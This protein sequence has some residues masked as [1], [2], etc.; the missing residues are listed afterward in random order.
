MKNRNVAFC[1]WISLAFATSGCALFGE[2]IAEEVANVI[3][4]YCSESQAQR[5]IYR[6]QVNA[7]LAAEGHQ[8]S[9]SCAGDTPGL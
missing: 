8:I 1:L 3:D 5:A 2:K 9:V 4:D 7:A 6:D